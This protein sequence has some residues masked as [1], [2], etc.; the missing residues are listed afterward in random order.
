[1]HMDVRD[2]VLIRLCEMLV[3]TIVPALFYLTG[4]KNYSVLFRDPRFK[5]FFSISILRFNRM[6]WPNI[7]TP[8]PTYSV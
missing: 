6:F 1:M 4:L 8:P 3:S 5:L 7:D 2:T